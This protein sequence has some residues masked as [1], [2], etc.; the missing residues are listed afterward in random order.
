MYILWHKK[1][2]F[3]PLL[4]NTYGWLEYSISKDAVFCYAC[5]FFSMGRIDELFVKTSYKDWKHATS[6]TG[7]LAKHNNSLKH[8]EAMASWIDF[9]DNQRKQKSVASSLNTQRKQQISN[10]RHYLKTTVEL[11]VFCASQEIGLRGHREQESVNKGNVLEFL[12]Q[13]ELRFDSKNVVVMNGIAECSPSSRMFLSYPN[14]KL[15]AEYYNISTDNL[16]V[17]VAL[18]SKVIPYKYYSFFSKLP[19]LFSACLRISIQ[20]LANR[21]HHSGYKC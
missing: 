16:Q 13:L 3:N 4:Y 7:R 6:T 2:S 12:Y 17:E 20:T 11:L 19:I 18:L 1:R 9:Q 10:N 15:F 21:P 5:R 8:K 14:L